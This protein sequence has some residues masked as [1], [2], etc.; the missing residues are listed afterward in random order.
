MDSI[1]FTPSAVLSLLSEI[2]ELKGQ[3]IVFDES[4]GSITF[5]IGDS[6]YTV[7]VSSASTVEVDD[8]TIDKVEEANEEGYS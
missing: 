7:D 4:A 2:E 3:E 1:V 5:K 6:S 8:E